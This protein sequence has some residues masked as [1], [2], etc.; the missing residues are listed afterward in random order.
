MEQN[1]AHE[2]MMTTAREWLKNKPP[3]EIAANGA[4]RFDSERSVFTLTSLGVNAE[5]SYPEYRFVSDIQPWHQLSIL[6]YLHLADGTA[7]TGE[8]ISLCQMNSGMIRGGGFDKMFEALVRTT[9]GNLPAQ[10]V[11]DACLRLGMTLERS[12]ADLCARFDLAP[13][14]PVMLKLWF[15]DP[16]DDLPGSGRVFVDRSAD[17]FLTIED[18]VLLCEYL[19][20]DRLKQELGI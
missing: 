12:N 4:I 17:H 2:R 7:P 6:H 14:F 15:A 18:A 13:L 9:L 10:S 11:K 20:V 1:N 19:I 5:I 16:E 8:W 3:E